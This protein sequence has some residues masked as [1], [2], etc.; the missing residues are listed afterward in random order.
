VVT[1]KVSTIGMCGLT[2]E[3]AVVEQEV[4]ILYACILLVI[5]VILKHFLLLIPHSS[6][7]TQKVS[8][9]TPSSV[10]W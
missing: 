9:I 5:K 3:K 10:A 4:R 8:G 1:V 6:G 7:V 2:P